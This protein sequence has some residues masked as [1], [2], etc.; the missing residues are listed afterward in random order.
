MSSKIIISNPIY[1]EVFRYLMD[2]LESAKIII[3]TLLNQTILNLKPLA[4]DLV[5]LNNQKHT[6]DNNNSIE[7]MRL[8]YSAEILNNDNTKELVTIE[9]QKAKLKTDE[10]RFRKYIAENLKKTEQI[11]T[12]VIDPNT[13]LPRVIEKTYR[14]IPIFILNFEIEKEICDLIIQTERN[15]HGIFTGK[16]LQ[17]QNEFL[18]N[19]MYNL[20]VVQIPYINKIKESDLQNDKHK[21]ALYKLFLLFNQSNP[22]DIENHSLYINEDEIPVEYARIVHRL[23]NVN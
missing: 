21:L 8:D 2:D 17:G 14:F 11:I 18:D 15:I 6:K 23:A 4:N 3:S 13:K 22:A 19:L 12:D 10:I 7:L 1:D 5:H 20:I 9:L 16:Q